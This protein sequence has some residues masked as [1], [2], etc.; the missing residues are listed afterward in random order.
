MS[1]V[2]DLKSFKCTYCQS[3]YVYKNSLQ[4]HIEH[5][6]AGVLFTCDICGDVFK[7]KDSVKRHNSLVHSQFQ[8]KI[9]CSF[10][11]KTFTYNPNLLKHVR[12]FHS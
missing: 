12:E 6:H 7:R 3:A 1:R 10:C 8:A 11:A 9:K 2:R 5:H 4:K